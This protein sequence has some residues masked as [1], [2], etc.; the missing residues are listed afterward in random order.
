MLIFLR[1]ICRYF[2]KK[3]LKYSDKFGFFYISAALQRMTIS[4]EIDLYLR[5]PGRGNVSL[6]PGICLMA[7]MII[8]GNLMFSSRWP[9]A[10]VRLSQETLMYMF[11]DLSF[12]SINLM[13][14][15]KF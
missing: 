2:L 3:Y 4:M 9:E 10:C 11:A 7:V 8:W 13:E 5:I 14:L 6:K 15:K 1:M 12:L